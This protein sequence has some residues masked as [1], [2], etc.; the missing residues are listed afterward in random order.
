MPW[1]SRTELKEIKDRLYDL[2]IKV[3]ELHRDAALYPTYLD[4]HDLA[5]RDHRVPAS[6]VL[7]QLLDHLGFRVRYDRG[8]SPGPVLAQ[9]EKERPEC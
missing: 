7:Q 4:V 3:I 2:E 9:G 8:R 1:I 5:K 6:S